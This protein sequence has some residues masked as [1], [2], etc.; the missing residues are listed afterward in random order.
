M[1]SNLKRKINIYLILLS[2]L[3]FTSLIIIDQFINLHSIKF[4][5]GYVI[6]ISLDVIKLI[7]GIKHKDKE[8][9][10]HGTF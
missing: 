9:I 4:F 6:G 2:V 10:K 8:F 5:S 1:N 7:I 3:L